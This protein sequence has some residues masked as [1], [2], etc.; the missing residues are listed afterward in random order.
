[1]LKQFHFNFNIRVFVNYSTLFLY[2][3][4]III[5]CDNKKTITFAKNSK[6]LFSNQV[7]RNSITFRSR[8]NCQKIYLIA[9]RFR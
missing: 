1:M 7:Y 8:E 6:K 5:Y 2:Y 9:I 3:M 4:I